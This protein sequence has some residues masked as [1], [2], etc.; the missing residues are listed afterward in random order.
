MN[1]T[2]LQIQCVEWC[3]LQ[4]PKNILW[5]A[6]ANE[7]KAKPQYMAKLKRMG[8]LTGVADLTF[9][10]SY[11][12]M[13]ECTMVNFVELKRPTTYKIGKRGKPVVDQS[14]GKQS[15]SQK[16]F[17]VRAVENNCSYV[18]IDNFDDFKKYIQI[19]VIN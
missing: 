11:G 2:D 4:L 10:T 17:E 8:M 3:H 12:L 1:E 7:R 5:Y 9:I 15:D 6:T 14:G 18:L 19:N 13:D 16:A